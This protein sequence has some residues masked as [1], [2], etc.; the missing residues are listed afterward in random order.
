MTTDQ[1]QSSQSKQSYVFV[2]TEDGLLYFIN[3]HTRQVDKIIQI[4]EE[5]I[6]AMVLARTS[7]F[8][9]SVSQGGTIRLWTTDF[10]NLKS[11]VK[12]GSPIS[13]CDVNYDGSQICVM[14]Q[15]SGTISVLDLATSSYNVVLRTHTDHVT[16]LAHNLMTGKLVTLGDDYCVKIWNAETMEQINEFVS[17]RDLPVRVVC[18]N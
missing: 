15:E 7:E 17:E 4:H 13:S 5:A 1:Q 3:Y 9:A 2:A 16:D 14:S 18:Q 11:E 6:V 12:T 10:E 8:I